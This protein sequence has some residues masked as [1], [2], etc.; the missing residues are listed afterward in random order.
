M[1][2]AVFASTCIPGS[3]SPASAVDASTRNRNGATTEPIR[4][5]FMMDS[6]LTLQPLVAG[7]FRLRLG[8]RNVT[9]KGTA[10]S[11]SALT[12]EDRSAFRPPTRPNLRPSDRSLAEERSATDV[13]RLFHGVSFRSKHRD[14]AGKERVRMGLDGV[15]DR[16]KRDQF[17][18]D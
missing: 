12:G 4:L 14:Q 7:V 6:L 5:L 1:T 13:L 15:L 10:T 18:T 8:W 11:R 17:A 2:S 16:L 9:K 3:G